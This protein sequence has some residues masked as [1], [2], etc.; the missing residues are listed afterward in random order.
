VEL[1]DL[2]LMLLW[3][4]G[5][6]KAFEVIYKRY[7]TRL[8]G[9]AMQKTGDRELAEEMIQDVFMS[10]YKQKDSASQL[11]SIM[12]YLYVLLKNRIFDAYRHEQVQRRYQDH[13]AY[14]STEADY[15]TISFIETRDLE[16]QLSLEIEK[17]PPQCRTVFKLSRQQYL[18]NKEIAALLKISENTV[19]QHMRKALRLLRGSL[20][21]YEKSL[22]ILLLLNL[23]K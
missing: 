11:S 6:N 15:S 9:I 3:Q 7:A 12:A 18:P 2:E 1:S 10:L 22:A 4:R 19:E 14:V 8:L 20:L 23:R 5:E 16:K 13:L 21:G 17:L